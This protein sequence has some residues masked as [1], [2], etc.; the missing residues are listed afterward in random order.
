[1]KQFYTIVITLLCIS[2]TI[3]Q[4]I[5]LTVTVPEGATSVKF[6]GPW[7]GWDP[8]GGPVA[9][10]NG[11]NTW[12]VNMPPGGENM[13]YL[14]VVDGVQENLVDNAANSECTDRID[15]G[16]MI[17]DYA[18]YA[19]RVW[20]LD[21]GDVSG[22]IY[23]SCATATTQTSN[24]TPSWDFEDASQI[25]DWT[26]VG[27]L[28]KSHVTSGGNPDGAM[29]FGGTNETQGS[30]PQ[31]LLEHVNANFDYLSAA[32]AKIKFD[33]LVETALVGTAIHFM[34]ETANVA[35]VNTF[36]LE[37]QGLNENT[38]TSYEI[39]HTL[40]GDATGLFKVLFNFAAGADAGMGGELLMDNFVI[41]LYDSS[42]GVLGISNISESIFMV[43][44][45]P[46]QNTLNVSTDVVVDQVSIFDL[47]GRQVMRA[48][49][50]AEEFSLDVTNLNKGLYLVTLKAGD[51]EMITK[52][53]K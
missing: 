49:P 48:T 15:A 5:N 47:T 27:D 43:Y 11:D 18:N 3:A 31:L 52:L 25:D 26:A 12:T 29:K 50:N 7:W 24:P 45:N 21:S 51:Q 32:T 35:A 34:H 6:T 20:L 1:M 42:G 22:D 33:L 37:N 53:V 28:V 10:S 23:D 14:W 9:T 16:T 36:N 39:E 8:N 19:N 41:E 2:L 13:E 4:N 40:S 17:T 38:W 30:A 44:P 46:V